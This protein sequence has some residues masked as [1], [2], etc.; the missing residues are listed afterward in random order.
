MHL[1]CDRIE[2]SYGSPKA[3]NKFMVHLLSISSRAMNTATER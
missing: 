3:V 1:D 2:G